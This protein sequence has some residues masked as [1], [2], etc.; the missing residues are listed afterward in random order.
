MSIFYLVFC[1]GNVPPNPRWGDKVVPQTP[2][3]NVRIKMYH[4]TYLLLKKIMKTHDKINLS[5][6]LFTDETV[7]QLR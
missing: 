7:G 3:N 6:V 5:L 4:F 2:R 1:G